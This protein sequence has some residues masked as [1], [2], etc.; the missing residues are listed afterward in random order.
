MFDVAIKLTEVEKEAS[1]SFTALNEAIRVLK[2]LE[3]LVKSSPTILWF[4]LPTEIYQKFFDDSSFSASQIVRGVIASIAVRIVDTKW[5][6]LV[7]CGRPFSG[8]F[9]ESR[10]SIKCSN[11]K[12]SYW[13]GAD[14]RSWI[15]A[16]AVH[17]WKLWIR[18]AA[19]REKR[20]TSGIRTVAE[21]WKIV[22]PVYCCTG[23]WR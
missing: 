1:L 3:P 2:E 7:D 14:W 4:Q 19:R 18:R 16:T 17:S 21:W 8:F 10:A 13:S 23:P 5:R 9:I 12:V 15:L 20:S 11:V 22:A 6:V